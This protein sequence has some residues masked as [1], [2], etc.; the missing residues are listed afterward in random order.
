MPELEKIPIIVDTSNRAYAE[1]VYKAMNNNNK[2]VDEA[3]RRDLRREVQQRE[4][5]Y[6]GLV[7]CKNGKPR[8]DAMERISNQDRVEIRK[9]IEEKKKWQR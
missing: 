2:K 3:Q 8:S 9:R 7:V 1:N 4:K 5:F 6:S